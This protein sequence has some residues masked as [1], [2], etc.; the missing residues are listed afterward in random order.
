MQRMDETFL[1]EIRLGRT[2]WRVNETISAIAEKFR[3]EGFYEKH[4]HV[5]L[6][7]PLSLNE[8]TSPES[9]LS[10]RLHAGT[11]PCLS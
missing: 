9:T 8:G 6:L 4:P 2:K 5:T 11:N 1:I 7:G 3:L 10:D